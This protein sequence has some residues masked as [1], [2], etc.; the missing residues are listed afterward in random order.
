[1]LTMEIAVTRTHHLARAAARPRALLSQTT[2]ACRAH[3]CARTSRR[4][5]IR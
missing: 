5:G 4:E 2:L 1:M 3:R